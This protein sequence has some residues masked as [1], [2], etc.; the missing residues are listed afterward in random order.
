MS[1]HGG[2]YGTLRGSNGH[3]GWHLG[4]LKDFKGPAGWDSTDHV[5]MGEDDPGSRNIMYKC[6]VQL[7]TASE[8]GKLCAWGRHSIPSSGLHALLET[9]HGPVKTGCHNAIPTLVGSDLHLGPLSLLPPSSFSHRLLSPLLLLVH[10]CLS[11]WLHTGLHVSED[12]II[13]SLIN[14]AIL[15]K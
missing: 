14:L 13:C 5:E 9:H 6:S 4:V 7:H 2:K 11:S 1:H 8:A 3:Q 10:F 12:Y 15:C